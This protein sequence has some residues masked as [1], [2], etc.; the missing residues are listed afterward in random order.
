MA[1][2]TKL[3]NIKKQIVMDDDL[4]PRMKMNEDQ[5]QEYADLMK[6]QVILPP[7]VVFWDGKKYWLADG[8]HRVEAAKLCEWE[9]IQCE[10]RPGGK[11]D[12]LLFSCGANATHGLKRT[13]EDKNRAVTS[14]V[15]DP[16]WSQWSDWQIS[17]H[18]GVS[19]K[20]V[21]AVRRTC[22]KAGTPKNAG[23]SG[24]VKGVTRNIPSDDSEPGDDSDDDFPGFADEP[25]T[26]KYITKH[27]TPATM[28]VGKIGKGTG[29]PA[30]APH[31]DSPA[32]GEPDNPKP[33][34]PEP[35]PPIDAPEGWEEVWAITPHLRAVAKQIHEAR[36]TL[37]EL[38]TRPGGAILSG[39]LSQIEADAKNITGSIG[40]SIPFALCSYCNGK[41]CKVCGNRGWENERTSKTAAKMREA[42]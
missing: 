10:V 2:E 7:P 16:E 1:F 28:K 30:K 6:E 17:K 32:S 40:Y 4:Q 24:G 27:G 33:S 8:F 36:R 25:A 5:A 22:G 26:R 11:R 29:T 15:L 12:A 41:K 18:C 37:Q 21:G 31:V 3:L 35:K 34:P 14:M 23:K 42:V 20:L 38:S 9:S 39:L 19:N 13:N